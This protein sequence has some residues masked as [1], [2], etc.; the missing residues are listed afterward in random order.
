MI[1]YHL[2]R[3]LYEDLRAPPAVST[4]TA[5]YFTEESKGIPAGGAATVDQA[6]L[7]GR[8]AQGDFRG[9]AERFAAVHPGVV[10]VVPRLEHRP[11][12]RLLGN[13]DRRIEL[14]KRPSSA[15]PSPVTS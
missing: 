13:D 15:L 9:I 14:R 6:A 11:Q 7:D 8:H 3:A 1:E 2:R 4:S 5:M 12:R 10:A